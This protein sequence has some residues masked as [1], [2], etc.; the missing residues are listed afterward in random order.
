M[1]FLVAILVDARICK[2]HDV[3]SNEARADPTPEISAENSDETSD[4]SSDESSAETSTE[5]SVETSP[6]T[7]PK[8]TPDASPVVHSYNGIYKGKLSVSNTKNMGSI[9]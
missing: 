9:G 4:E 5:P 2:A 8:T 1:S 3:T 6:V 7:T